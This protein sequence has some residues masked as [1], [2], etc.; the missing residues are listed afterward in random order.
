PLACCMTPVRTRFAGFTAALKNGNLGGRPAAHAACQAEFANSH[1]CHEAEYLRAAAPQSIPASGAWIDSS[2]VNGSTSVTGG[3]PQ[4]GR[5]TVGVCFN[6][7][8]SLNTAG[9][10]VLTQAGN[11]TS[12]NDCSVSHPLACCGGN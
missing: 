10:Y 2:T 1:L 4:G 3:A 11:V 12:N 6:W 8:S 9:G 7:T 5:Y